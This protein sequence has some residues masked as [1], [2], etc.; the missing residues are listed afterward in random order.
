MTACIAEREDSIMS[1]TSSSRT[2]GLSIDRQHLLNKMT[3][4]IDG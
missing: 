3:V 4:S 1:I 2:A